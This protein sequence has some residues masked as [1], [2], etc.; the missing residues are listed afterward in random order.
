MSLSEY[1]G[2]VLPVEKKAN[3]IHYLQK[4]NRTQIG[5][6]RSLLI[7][8]SIPVIDDPLK[9]K[10]LEIL[11]DFEL[12]NNQNAVRY[13]VDK[14]PY[15]WHAREWAR[16]IIG[17]H[18]P[19]P[20]ASFNLYANFAGQFPHISREDES[21]IAVIMD[22]KKAE[23]DLHTTMKIGR[24]LSKQTEAPESAIPDIS[25]EYANRSKVYILEEA[26]TRAEIQWVYENGPTS[27]MAKTMTAGVF[28]TQVHPTHAY[29]TPDIKILFVRDLQD[30]SRV[31][32]RTVASA[33]NN[34][35]VRIFGNEAV[36]QNLLNEAS[37]YNVRQGG[38]ANHR[39][40]KIT[41][42]RNGKTMHVG[43]YLDS[44]KV[45][46]TEDPDDD[47][48]LIIGDTRPEEQH[49]KHIGHS[50]RSY[51]GK[52]YMDTPPL[53]K[54]HYC[55]GD[56]TEDSIQYYP[57]SNIHSCGS[58]REDNM[59]ALYD[60]N[61]LFVYVDTSYTDAYVVNIISGT[62]TYRDNHGQIKTKQTITA[63]HFVNE[64]AFRNA[65]LPQY[66]SREDLYMMRSSA[67]W[68]PNRGIFV[69]AEEAQELSYCNKT[70]LIEDCIKINGSL[71]A[72][73]HTKNGAFQFTTLDGYNVRDILDNIST[74]YFRHISL[75][76]SHDKIAIISVSKQLKPGYI[77][78][79]DFWLQRIN[80][81]HGF[82]EYS[83]VRTKD[84]MTLTVAM[85]V[86]PSDC[87]NV[88]FEDRSTHEY[89]RFRVSSMAVRKMI[90]IPP[91]NTQ[92]VIR[93]RSQDQPIREKIMKKRS[94]VSAGTTGSSLYSSNGTSWTT[95][96]A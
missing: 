73:E 86:I 31:I 22:N 28:L 46:I 41:E 16:F 59:R 37:I 25:N 6:V 15:W 3:V 40:L 80:D 39:L 84:I 85:C 72:K 35:Y 19:V 1:W 93:S 91:S 88:L 78:L 23:A 63:T 11:T 13:F 47:K 48:Y 81:A 87:N 64:A 32:S 55:R 95:I 45:N 42:E 65:E 17:Y 33:I 89:S 10:H 9:A 96:S 29:A 4:L 83:H 50:E 2:Q 60:A 75:N 7:E 38:L 53:L 18:R 54:C 66:K 44:G 26:R 56:F 30:H 49:G 58:C 5:R 69:L 57:L 34:T 77:S 52:G 70:Y 82:N 68:V 71:V 21:R 20:S 27:C 43:P 51:T 14:S 24:Y 67:V 8:L 79:N 74:Y 36:M 92:V 12:Y 90:K 61:L 94:A 76:S 62:S